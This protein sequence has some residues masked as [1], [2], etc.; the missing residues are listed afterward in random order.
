M[1]RKWSQEEKDRMRE[2]MR[3]KHA[4]RVGTSNFAGESLRGYGHEIYRRDNFTCRYCGADGTESFH[5]WLT[6]TCDHLLPKNHPHRD[7]KDYIVTACA[8]CNVAD[9]HYFNKA[10][11][12]GLTFDDMTPDQLVEQRRP[13]VFARREEY[14]AF[15]EANVK[16]FAK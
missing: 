11:K 13:Y 16:T 9:N 7:D 3:A 8:F 2:I 4:G 6:L 12:L 15:W 10:K 1:G 14:K 5:V